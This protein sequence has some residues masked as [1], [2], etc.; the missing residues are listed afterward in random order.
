MCR[1]PGTDLLRQAL[2]A[3]KVGA[4]GC[5]MVGDSASDCGAA[6]GL[7]LDFALVLTGHGR[8]KLKAATVKPDYILNSIAELRD[9][10]EV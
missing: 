7:G 9:I 4:Q 8:D 2:E 1:T 6:K 10:I 3:G 5:L